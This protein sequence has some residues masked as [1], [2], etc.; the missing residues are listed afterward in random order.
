MGTSQNAPSDTNT[1]PWQ[2]SRRT[3]FEVL[4]GNWE[5]E[6]H[7]LAVQSAGRCVVFILRLLVVI[8]VKYI[9]L[10]FSSD[11]P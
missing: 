9:I 4:T 5:R 10:L 11:M 8:R 3:F 7:V 1:K 6:L 2:P